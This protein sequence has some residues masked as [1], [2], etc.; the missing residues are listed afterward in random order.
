MGDEADRIIINVGGIAYETYISTLQNIPDTRLAWLAESIDPDP[1]NRKEIFFDRHSGV[2]VH[3]LNYYRTGKL[4]TPIDICGPLFEEELNFWG[5]DEKQMEP[6]CWE[7]FTKH[8]EAEVN[9]KSFE[10]P[11]FEDLKSVKSRKFSSFGSQ[12][13][14]SCRERM[15]QIWSIMDRPHS[16]NIAKYT[17]ILSCVM[18]V[19]SVTV[20]CL[21]TLGQLKEDK[22][23]TNAKYA[24]NM[25]CMCWFTI[26]FTVRI[27]V[28]PDR[29]E[30]AKSIGNWV[31]FISVIPSYLNLFPVRYTLLKNLVIIRLLRLFRFFKLSYG[32]QVLLHT[33]KASSYELTLLL[34]ILLIPIVIFSSLVYVIETDSKSKFTSIPATFWWCLI[35]MTSVG[36]GDMVPETWAGKMIGSM[37]AT[38]GVLI[39]ALPISVIGSN[40]SLYYAH[41]RARLKLPSKDRKILAG[42]IR[43]LLKQ[44]LSLSSRERDRRV[45]KRNNLKRK[46]AARNR[47]IGDESSQQSSSTTSEEEFNS[48]SPVK[49]IASSENC[50]DWDSTADSNIKFVQ[51]RHRRRRKCVFKQTVS[52]EDDNLVSGGDSCKDM[53]EEP[54]LRRSRRGAHATLCDMDQGTFSANS[55]LHSLKDAKDSER[56]ERTSIESKNEPL[57]SKLRSPSVNS[58]FSEA[59]TDRNFNTTSNLLHGQ[60][61]AE[62]N[63][64]TSMKLMDLE[65]LPNYE[66]KLEGRELNHATMGA[67]KNPSRNGE[68]VNATQQLEMS[69][70]G[71]RFSKQ[72]STNAL[73]PEAMNH[74]TDHLPKSDGL[75][76]EVS[77]KESK[78][79][80]RR[81]GLHCSPTG[82]GPSTL[83]IRCEPNIR[84]SKSECNLM[85]YGNSM[86]LPLVASEIELK[87]HENFDK[88]L[89]FK[90]SNT[91]YSASVPQAHRGA[92]LADN[93]KSL[94]TSHCDKMENRKKHIESKY[95]KSEQNVRINGGMRGFSTLDQCPRKTSSN[96]DLRPLETGI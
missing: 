28:C 78:I 3:I 73:Q 33:L 70:T 14:M 10:G 65:T 86:P 67:A 64:R 20:Y 87:F 32:L 37:C 30:F 2:F 43:G 69:D 58:E 88:A 55:S 90:T 27:L 25:L 51:K 29:R 42:N 96:A 84:T 1:S 56:D 52:H 22:A 18:I 41:V 60:S 26:E 82:N 35:T 36:Y 5:I 72:P 53:D 81:S 6:C 80:G 8:R 75:S 4:H 48:G 50:L 19:L 47:A 79:F 23:W 61:V 45:V 68:G 92:T 15:D 34:L 89:E 21:D 12:D 63:R 40:F 31:D 24:I 16:S 85:P 38:C 17:S 9:L 13:G 66:N 91:D 94:K 74:T 44:P 7:S 59:L 83:Q 46:G 71:L 11:G 57:C 49:Q 62:P 39:V 76:L 93:R 77:D 95:S 54:T